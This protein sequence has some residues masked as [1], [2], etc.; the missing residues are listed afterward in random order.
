MHVDCI[1][2]LCLAELSYN[3]YPVAPPGAESPNSNL[4][5]ITVSER[6]EPF[7]MTMLS[8]LS[9]ATT[10]A[11]QAARIAM[12]EGRQTAP[13]MSKGRNGPPERRSRTRSCNEPLSSHH[14]LSTEVKSSLSIYL[15]RCRRAL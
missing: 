9:V 5:E 4:P 7:F 3:L 13:N 12:R 6:R 1:L 8:D 2:K 14:P 15:N 11:S 10:G